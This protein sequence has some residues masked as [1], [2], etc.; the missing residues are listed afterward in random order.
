MPGASLDLITETN[1]LEAIVKIP[2]DSEF[3]EMARIK[4]PYHRMDYAVPLDNITALSD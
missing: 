3:M 2:F 1:G 4:D